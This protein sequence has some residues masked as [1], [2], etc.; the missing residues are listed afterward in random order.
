[1]WLTYLHVSLMVVGQPKQNGVFDRGVLNPRDLA[2]IG[3]R[4]RYNP[5]FERSIFVPSHVHRRRPWDFDI[6]LENLSLADN[7]C[8]QQALAGASLTMDH[9]GDSQQKG[10]RMLGVCIT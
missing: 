1:M 8:Q 5:V 9:A 10:V 6:A 7:S 2:H 3:N 4:G